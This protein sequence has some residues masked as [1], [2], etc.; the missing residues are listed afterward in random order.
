MYLD[1][2]CLLKH[3]CTNVLLCW[4]YKEKR[5]GMA[6]LQLPQTS[7]PV[8]PILFQLCPSSCFGHYTWAWQVPSV[9][10]FTVLGFPCLAKGSWVWAGEVSCRSWLS[11]MRCEGFGMATEPWGEAADGPRNPRDCCSSEEASLLLPHSPGVRQRLEHTTLT[12]THK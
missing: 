7:K 6:Q 5:M 10:S 11:P 2:C 12:V 1:F 4:E 8:A 9:S 3:S